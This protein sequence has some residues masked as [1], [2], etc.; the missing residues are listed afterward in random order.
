MFAMVLHNAPGREQREQALHGLAHD[1]YAREAVISTSRYDEDFASSLRLLHAEP[2]FRSLHRLCR[3]RQ[4]GPEVESTTRAET[5]LVE[6]VLERASNHATSA[7][8]GPQHVT[9]DSLERLC[10][11]HDG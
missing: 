10:V 2:A 1:R 5:E 4:R 6:R 7:Q 8:R 11:E 3:C 9:V